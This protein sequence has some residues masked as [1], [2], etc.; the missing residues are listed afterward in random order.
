MRSLTSDRALPKTFELIATKGPAPHDFDVLIALL[1][2][3]P[4]GT[5]DRVRDTANEPFE[6]DPER[7]RDDLDAVLARESAS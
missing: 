4:Q 1:D 5:L 7:V 3:D 2:A 6:E